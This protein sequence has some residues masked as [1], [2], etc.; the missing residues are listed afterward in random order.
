MV[1]GAS[2]TKFLLLNHPRM[3]VVLGYCIVCFKLATACPLLIS[4]ATPVGSEKPSADRAEIWLTACHRP[5]NNFNQK[6]GS[7]TR[8]EK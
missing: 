6:I 5:S 3:I 4:E 7:I 8:E 2:L 1:V